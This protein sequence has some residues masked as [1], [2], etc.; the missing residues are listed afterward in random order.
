[1]TT[2]YIGSKISLISKSEIRYE[3]ILYT[4]DPKES[5][6]ALAK[7]RC[8]GTETRIAASSIDPAPVPPRDEIYEYI[9]F[10]ASDIK[11]LTVCETP[12]PAPNIYASAGLPHDPAILSAS[13]ET[14]VTGHLNAPQQSQQVHQNEEPAEVRIESPEEQVKSQLASKTENAA[15]QTSNRQKRNS[16][17]SQNAPNRRPTNE[18]QR[19]T[20]KSGSGGQQ[21]QMSLEDKAPGAGRQKKGSAGAGEE[22]GAEGGG[23]HTRRD[24]NERDRDK[25]RDRATNR[26]RRQQRRDRDTSG[27]IATGRRRRTSTNHSDQQQSQQRVRSSPNF[28]RPRFAPM[29]PPNRRFYNGNAMQFGSTAYPPPLFAPGGSPMRRGG[30]RGG[31]VPVPANMIPYVSGMGPGGVGRYRR[32]DDYN[33]MMPYQ[34]RGPPRYNRNLTTKFD[35]DYD[36]EKA[37]EEFLSGKMIKLGLLGDKP[38]PEKEKEAEQQD[39]S[40]IAEVI[41]KDHDSS[42]SSDDKLQQQQQQTPFYDRS[43]SFFDRISCES[44]ERQS[45]TVGTTP[46]AALEK[47]AATEAAMPNDETKEEATSVARGVPPQTTTNTTS[48]SATARINARNAWRHERELNQL[49]FGFAALAPRRDGYRGDYGRQPFSR[50]PPLMAMQQWA[51]PMNYRPGYIPR[52]GMIGSRYR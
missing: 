47:V 39:D 4:I 17:P 32:Y 50:V 29:P 1:M 5:T 11:D 20:A 42:A 34:P 12:Q 9:I 18:K 23:G 41:S 38:E 36:F 26:N 16:A 44:L 45:A 14:S 6:I 10:K 27:E 31:F 25:E 8:F 2:P 33:Q 37:N 21:N 30:Y 13:K 19:S 40:I 51:P 24:T 3:G 22:K 7:V 35:S 43:V 49:T 46:A 52:G 28:R 48:F 15:S